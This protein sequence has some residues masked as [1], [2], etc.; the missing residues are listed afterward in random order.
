MKKNVEILIKNV[1]NESK[2]KVRAREFKL[3]H[4]IMS[5]AA[6]RGTFLFL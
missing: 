2:F 5:Y 4:S 3:A 6:I 1:E